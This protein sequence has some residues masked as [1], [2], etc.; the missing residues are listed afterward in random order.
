MKRNTSITERLILYYVVLSISAITM[1][2][3]I[4]YYLAKDALMDRTFNQLTSVR[5][6]KTKQLERFF[7]DRENDIKKISESSDIKLIASVSA[8]QKFKNYKI[9]IHS[10]NITNMLKS[11]IYFTKLILTDALFE[12]TLIFSKQSDITYDKNYFKILNIY[13]EQLK[14]NSIIFF[15]GLNET[16]ENIIY[17]IAP[18]TTNKLG[19]GYC[20]LAMDYSEINKIMLENNHSSGLGESG[21]SYLVGTDLKMR[22]QSRFI[23]NSIKNVIVKTEGTQSVLNGNPGTGIFKD[24]RGIEVLSSYSK[25]EL[26]NLQ[27]MILAEIDLIEAEQPII[28]LRN[29]LLIVIAITSAITFI[30]TFVLSKRISN[31]IIKLTNAVSSFSKGEFKK[32]EVPTK[33]EIEILADTFNEMAENLQAKEKELAEEKSK[34]LKEVIDKLDS[35]RERLSR[36]LHDGIGQSFIAMKLKLENCDFETPETANEISEELKDNLNLIIDDVRRISN[37]LMPAVLYEFGLDTA[38]RNL[39]NNIKQISNIDINLKLN[40]GSLVL[41]KNPKIY[42]FRIIQEAL[43]NAIKHSSATEIK[44][45]VHYNN[46]QLVIEIRDNGKGFNLNDFESGMGNGLHNMKERVNLLNGDFTIES[47]L[48]KGTK[49]CAVFELKDGTNK[50]NIS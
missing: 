4:F 19:A 31:P 29:I 3:A 49:I 42:I 44:V 35:E 43:N 40:I 25:I 24:Y 20:I 10:E 23:E 14:T 37:D 11:N 46:Q 22:S 33:D 45:N 34:R 27:W 50:H 16:G 18:I 5:V 7:I 48:E 28:Y 21:E 17:L 26:M 1:V 12:N 32:V 6:V 47:E 2:G 39:C 30:I 8:N 9:N 15:E 38:I 36:E 13:P 41:D